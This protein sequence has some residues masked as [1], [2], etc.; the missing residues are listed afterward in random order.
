MPWGFYSASAFAKGFTPVVPIAYLNHVSQKKKGITVHH[1]A[2]K[3]LSTITTNKIIKPKTMV[4]LW[5][6][7]ID[8]PLFINLLRANSLTTNFREL[9]TLLQEFGNHVYFRYLVG[10]CAY[11][12]KKVDKK[13]QFFC[14]MYSLT[15]AKNIALKI[16]KVCFI[17]KCS[18]PK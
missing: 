11:I 16:G 3:L 14:T 17:T 2:S 7:M 18:P 4:D 6:F 13:C 9:N 5:L 12:E 1:F 10:I 15:D 8:I